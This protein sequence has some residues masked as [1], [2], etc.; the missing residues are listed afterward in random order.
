MYGYWDE[1]AL[2][3]TYDRSAADIQR[4]RVE[5]MDAKR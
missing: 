3:G 4:M 5:A 2:G 1:S